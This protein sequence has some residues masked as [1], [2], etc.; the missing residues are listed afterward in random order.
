MAATPFPSA[1]QT[2]SKNGL[3]S[4]KKAFDDA[5]ICRNYKQKVIEDFFKGRGKEECKRPIAVT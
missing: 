5:F 3:L 4:P 2:A 1:E